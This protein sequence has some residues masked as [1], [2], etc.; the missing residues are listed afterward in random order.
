MF[1][2]NRQRHF[3]TQCSTMSTI[4]KKFTRSFHH[5]LKP[6]SDPDQPGGHFN[7]NDVNDH[8]KD[9]SVPFGGDQ[10]TRVRFVG[11]KD[12]R[13]GCHSAKD[14]F[15]HV[16]PFPIELFHTKMSFLQ[17]TYLTHKHILMIY[18][19]KIIYSRV[20]KTSMKPFIIFFFY[21]PNYKI[22]SKHQID[23]RED[24]Q[25]VFNK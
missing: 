19:Q 15:D 5:A 10:V 11:A 4:T 12:L 18:F 1:S 25:H 24:L 22:L 3:W 17:V 20:T 13:Q 6:H 14:R 2:K 8:M 9:I 7:P 23:S 16:S 21:T